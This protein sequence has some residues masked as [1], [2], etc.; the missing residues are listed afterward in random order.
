MTQGIKA[1]LAPLLLCTAVS[2]SAVEIKF[3]GF[4]ANWENISA[5]SGGGQPT[6]GG[7]T[8]APT[9]RWGLAATS[10]GKSG[11]NFSSQNPF[12]IEFDVSQ[13]QSNDFILGTFTHLNN[14]IYSSGSSLFSADLRL[15]TDIE[16]DGQAINDID[17]LFNFDHDETPNS[18]N[19]CRYGPTG[20]TGINSNGCA[21][22]VDASTASFSDTFLINNIEY[23]LNIRGFEVGG[24]FIE[25]FLTKER[26]RNQAFIVANVSAV[27]GTPQVISSPL[28]ITLFASGL[29]AIFWL[30]RNQQSRK[31]HSY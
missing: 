14:P 29:F 10:S 9:L 6:T 5:R 31:N 26:V 23:T 11:Y 17:F 25:R 13:A 21:D 27:G 2:A 24:Q 30:R 20:Q 18:A 7:T 1:L 28:P 19:P 15:S 12:S 22:R 3:S 16:I 8:S 4:E